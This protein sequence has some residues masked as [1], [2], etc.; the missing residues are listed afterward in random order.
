MMLAD[1][2]TKHDDRDDDDGDDRRSIR[3]LCLLGC[4]ELKMLPVQDIIVVDYQKENT[5]QLGLK[6]VIRETSSFQH[7]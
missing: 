5:T 4:D 6:S 3:L 2:L 7:K 1:H